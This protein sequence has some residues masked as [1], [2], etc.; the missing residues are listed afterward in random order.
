MIFAFV[1]VYT[2]CIFLQ[3]AECIMT[4]D[5]SEY[6]LQDMESESAISG[7]YVYLCPV[8]KLLCLQLSF[9]ILSP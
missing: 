1:F 7:M 4:C 2:Y 8:A 6:I 5:L 9:S 3:P